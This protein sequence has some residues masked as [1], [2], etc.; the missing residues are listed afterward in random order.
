MFDEFF[1]DYETRRADLGE[2][3]LKLHVAL[4]ELAT[5]EEWRLLEK[6]TRRMTT[7]L[8]SQDLAG[9]GG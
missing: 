3:V 5:D 1:A 8:L 2:R 6:E 9:S 7:A 4:K